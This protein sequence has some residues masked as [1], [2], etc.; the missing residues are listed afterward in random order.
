MFVK[1]S[2]G[3]VVEAG[4]TYAPLNEKLTLAERLAMFGIS[5]PDATLVEEIR[6][7]E[8]KEELS[9]TPSVERMVTI[10]AITQS[11]AD[12]ILA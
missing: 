5:A 11:R 6:K 12:E 10:G 3:V 1:Y 8:C 2:N 7:L 4:T 9:I